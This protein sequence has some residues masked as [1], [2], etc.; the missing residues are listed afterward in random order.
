M[1]EEKK[2]R[3]K[4]TQDAAT[5]KPKRRRRRNKAAFVRDVIRRIEDKLTDDAK[6][7]VGDFIRLLQLEKELEEEQPKEIQVS[8]VEPERNDAPGK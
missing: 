3:A 6:P 1:G 5:P 7:S 8:W 2:G 4:K